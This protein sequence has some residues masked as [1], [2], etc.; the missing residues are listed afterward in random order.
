MYAWSEKVLA[1]I[2]IVLC[3]VFAGLTVA[4]IIVL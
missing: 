1:N 2:D 4:G 3:W